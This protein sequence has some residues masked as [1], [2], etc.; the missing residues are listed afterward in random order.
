MTKERIAVQFPGS[1]CTDEKLTK[2]RTKASREAFITATTTELLE[3]GLFWS[4]LSKTMTIKALIAN[5][6]SEVI[7]GY[8][9]HLDDHSGYSRIE[10]NPENSF[11]EKVFHELSKR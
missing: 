4:D 10:T 7:N 6:K 5:P 9:Q 2:N 3:K 11:Y 8:H 1:F